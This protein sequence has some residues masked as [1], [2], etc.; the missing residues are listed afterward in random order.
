[1][2]SANNGDNWLVL[3]STCIDSKSRGEAWPA[4]RLSS[5]CLR[6]RLTDEKGAHTE[7][8]FH[9]H[10]HAQK[11]ARLNLLQHLIDDLFRREFDTHR[12]RLFRSGFFKRIELTL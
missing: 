6:I 8:L 11:S 2:R 12:D 7:H 3:D 9:I 10:I 5:C 4:N 1:M